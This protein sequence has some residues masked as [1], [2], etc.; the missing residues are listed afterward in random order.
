[1]L[2]WVLSIAS[3]D[4]ASAFF[5]VAIQDKYLSNREVCIGQLC[6]GFTVRRMDG[7]SFSKVTNFLVVCRLLVKIEI[8]D[9][10]RLDQTSLNH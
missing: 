1:M 10:S 4:D 3:G 5:C 8:E 6:R 2:F 7:R 9:F